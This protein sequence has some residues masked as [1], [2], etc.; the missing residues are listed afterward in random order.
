M[1]TATGTIKRLSRL[2]ALA[3]EAFGDEKAASIFL[4]SV[5]PSLDGQSP[6][7]AA[8]T[9]SG[10]ELVEEILNKGLHGHPL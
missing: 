3:L 10:G 2:H 4:L 9:Q 6:F 5:H 8:L 1:N 7:Q